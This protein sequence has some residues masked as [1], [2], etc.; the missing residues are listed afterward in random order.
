[1]PECSF[2]GRRPFTSSSP[3]F[4]R[5]IGVKERI[6]Q[7]LEQYGHAIMRHGA[8][9]LFSGMVLLPGEDHRSS[10][11][12]DAAVEGQEPRRRATATAAV[13]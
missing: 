10:D 6:L 7:W 13:G 3:A 8:V 9:D 4:V 12:G 2:S 11:D 5:V 1:M